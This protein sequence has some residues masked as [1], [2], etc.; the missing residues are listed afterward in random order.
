VEP[1]VGVDPLSYARSECELVARALG[2]V[3]ATTE[4]IGD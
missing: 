3:P 2:L 1:G 4:Y